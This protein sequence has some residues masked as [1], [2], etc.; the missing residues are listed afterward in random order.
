M[1]TI[2]ILEDFEVSCS[3]LAKI[4]RDGDRMEFSLRAVGV[5]E[6][7]SYTARWGAV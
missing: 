6:E 4:D 2:F 3:N 5:M 1:K 7:S